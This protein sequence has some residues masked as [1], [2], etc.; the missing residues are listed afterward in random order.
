MSAFPHTQRK[1]LGVILPF[2]HLPPWSVGFQ[3]MSIFTNT[4]K[5]WSRTN[6]AKSQLVE[7]PSVVREM[8]RKGLLSKQG[9]AHNDGDCMK[10][11]GSILE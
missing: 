4:V 5:H 11:R 1:D 9:H 2:P 10:F 3:L 8:T 6:K 7:N